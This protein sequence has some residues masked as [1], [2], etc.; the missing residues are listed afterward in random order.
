M[1]LGWGKVILYPFADQSASH[2]IH[3]QTF[4]NDQS[5][6]VLRDRT[7]LDVGLLKSEVV[8]TIFA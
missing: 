4:G 5:D 2:T 8:I 7:Q 6:W 1:D 3:I